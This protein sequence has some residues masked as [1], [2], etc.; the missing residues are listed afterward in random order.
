MSD[1][2]G[3]AVKRA[4]QSR[5][6]SRAHLAL[7]ATMSESYLRAVETGHRPVTVDLAQRLDRALGAGGLIEELYAAETG[8]DDMRRRVVLAALGTVAGLGA[9]EPAYVV[10]ESLRT[11]LLSAYGGGD[12]WPDVA[13]EYGRRFM[14]DAPAVFRSCLTGD[15]M[16]LRAQITAGADHLA[17][18]LTAP[19]LMALAGM[20]V[21]N[22]GDVA[23]AA[24][25]YRSA[26]LAA[27]RTDDA[28]L[29]Q[30][31]R[32]R[33]AFRR[34]YE[35]GTPGEVL[36]IGADVQDVEAQLAVAQAYARA[37][38]RTAALAA[39]DSARR[40]HDRGDQAEGTIYAMPPWRW[41]LSAAYV[42][43][44]LGDISANADELDGVRPPN[45]VRR[46]EAQLHM[47]RAVAH[48]R[49]GD[50]MTGLDLARDTLHRL[51]DDQRSV[52]LTE[53]A[54]EVRRC[55]ARS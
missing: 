55:E 40:L 18:R 45:T 28:A 6:M 30:W 10:A 21:G 23:A 26:R 20:A 24:R 27:D 25:W 12:D 4:R 43:A 17:V 34:G 3:Q 44:L 16:V 7:A 33:E 52:V 53:M 2:I 9:A 29:Q 50:T 15:L 1:T 13:T 35:G 8:G 41:H 47:E 51:P 49:A 5:G 31:T 32:G 42:Y 14:T 46:W 37:G 19:R 22:T 48:A 54:R 38:E 36:A 11:S 39:L